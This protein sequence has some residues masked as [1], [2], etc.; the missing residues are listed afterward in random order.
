MRDAA[1][2][3]AHLRQY[4]ALVESR[5]TLLKLRPNVRQSWVALAVAHHL[6]GD[7]VE[8]E[9]II[10]HYEQTLRVGPI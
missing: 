4:D 7:L 10:S 5:L 8:A 3:Q 2:I 6:I 1:T 9:K